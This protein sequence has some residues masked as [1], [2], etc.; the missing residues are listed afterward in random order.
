M[1]ASMPSVQRYLAEFISKS[2]LGD[3]VADGGAAIVL[4]AETASSLLDG[5]YGTATIVNVLTGRNRGFEQR[6]AD[7][8]P[9]G[10]YYGD[11]DW[12]KK[13]FGGLLFP[14]GQASILV[15][16]INANR[17][18]SLLNGTMRLN[19][20]DADNTAPETSTDPTT[21][22]T[23][24]DTVDPTTDANGETAADRGRRTRE[25]SLQTDYSNPNYTRAQPASGPR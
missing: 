16:Y 10:E 3:F 1:I 25:Q 11:S 19:T 2:M 4:A 23:V 13:V 18:E 15:P 5:E 7:G 9:T 6:E 21:D 12:A 17:R 24:D 8:A 20:M 22:D 14:P